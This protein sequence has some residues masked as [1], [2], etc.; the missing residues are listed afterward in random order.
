MPT[1]VPSPAPTG[2]GCIDGRL[3]GAETDIDCGGDNCP[4][5]AIGQTCNNGTD[6][7]TDTCVDDVCVGAPTSMPSPVPTLT[8]SPECPSGESLY[9]LELTDSGGDGWEGR[10]YQIVGADA[11][12]AASGTLSDGGSGLEYVCLPDGDY[13]LELLACGQSGGGASGD[14]ASDDGS[15]APSPGPA[16]D[17]DDQAARSDDDATPRLCAA[18]TE[19]MTTRA[20]RFWSVRT[21][22]LTA[23]APPR[24]TMRATR[25]SQRSA[26][27]CTTTR[28]RQRRRCRYR[29]LRTRRPSAR[30]ASRCTSSS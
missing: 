13:E 14:G 16:D 7:T 18:R 3:N 1:P 30:A 6:C 8:P 20:A 11:S 4:A 28:R 22:A 12:V 17:D 10:T 9:K 26:V 19:R 15:A 2:V 24:R 5:C 25:R 27:W 23:G 29:R 21:A